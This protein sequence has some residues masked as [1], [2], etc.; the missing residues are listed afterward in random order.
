MLGTN[1]VG[2]IGVVVIGVVLRGV[3]FNAGIVLVI[4][5]EVIVGVVVTAGA[6]AISDGD[7]NAVTVKVGVVV[8]K[9][10][11]EELPIDGVLNSVSDGANAVTNDGD[12]IDKLGTA[13]ANAGAVSIPAINVLCGDNVIVCVGEYTT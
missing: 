5:P 10:F 8:L 3:D 12:A 2:V 7:L 13:S 11:P 9:V 1:P 6:V 4:D